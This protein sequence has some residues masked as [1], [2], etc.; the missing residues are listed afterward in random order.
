MLY[1]GAAALGAGAAMLM[2][3][4]DDRHAR[5]VVHGHGGE[6]LGRRGD[7]RPARPRADQALR[8][9]SHVL[10]HGPRADQALRGYS[11]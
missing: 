6:A 4:L 1:G 10:P 7:A 11:R 3:H 2:N 9:Y 5:E 8:G